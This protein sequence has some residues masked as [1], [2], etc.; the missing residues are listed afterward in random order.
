[1]KR[2]IFTFFI[3]G[4]FFFTTV[5]F[6]SWQIS[7]PLIPPSSQGLNPKF[8]DY[9]GITHVHSN[10]STGS[11]SIIEIAKA[12]ARANCQF[13]IVTDLN[14][15]GKQ[16]APEGYHDDVMIILASEYSYMS[17]HLLTYGFKDSASFKGLG[18][19]QIMFNE[20]LSQKPRSPSEGILVA[21]HPFL[22][23][24]RFE[25]LDAPGL[26]GMEIINLNSIWRNEITGRRL[27]LLWSFLILPF[28]PDLSYLRIFSEPTQELAAWD[29]ILEKRPFVGFAGS[30]ATA[31]AI[32]FPQKSFD[33]PSYAQSFRLMKNHVL[34]KSELTGL[35]KEDREKIMDALARGSFYFSL[36][37]I[38]DPA[39]FYFI[40]RKT[41]GKQHGE[42]LPGQ[43]VILEK[44]PITLI[45]DIGKNI[46]LPHE[47][48]LYRNGVKVAVSNSSRLTYE[49]RQPGA[50]RT[51]VRVIPTLPLPDGKTWF[52]W[53]YSNAIRIE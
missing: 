23:H 44:Y 20:Y 12:A 4:I 36:D 49:A 26:S 3:F 48:I 37:V 14:F 50:Y 9:A 39:G 27:N 10:R 25:N 15:T 31:N 30:D 52:P 41:A 6:V 21:P 42:H 53:I 7:F 32:P 1:V 29:R 45:A 16:N 24:H 5:A 38:G 46:D 18:Q 34:L 13:V 17:G 2:W 22:D 11:G 33:F 35:F 19:A 28:H 51:T 40:A 8:Y 43:T 47:I